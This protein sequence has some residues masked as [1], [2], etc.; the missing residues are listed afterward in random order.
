MTRLFMLNKLLDTIF[1]FSLKFGGKFLIIDAEGVWREGPI[2]RGGV[3][4]KRARTIPLYN[5]NHE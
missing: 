1:S 4:V 5:M 2:H 3:V